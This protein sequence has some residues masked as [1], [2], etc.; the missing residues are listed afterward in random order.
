ME[1][2][3]VCRFGHVCTSRCGNDIDCPCQADHCCALTEDCEGGEH[4]D[5]HFGPDLADKVNDELNDR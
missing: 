5:D 1:K 4:C 2:E 3:K